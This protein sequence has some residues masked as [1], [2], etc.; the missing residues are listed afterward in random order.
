MPNVKS[1]THVAERTSRL[2]FSDIVRIRNRVLDMIGR[3]I[4]VLRLEGGEPF[5][6]TP[7]F[8][9]QALK[10][11]VDA[12]QTR[13]A[14]SSG[15]PDLL[16]AI[17]A[18][19][20]SKNR[21]TVPQSSVIVTSGGAHGL[22][23]A[24]QATVN[25]GDEVML[26][27]PFW[28]PIR[29]HITYAGG[30]PVTVPW[31]EVRGRDAA[32][33]ALSSRL[34]PLTRVIYLNTPGN[35]T[36]DVL[37]R[38]QLASIAEFAIANDLT[39][40]ADEAYE[41]LQYEG[42]HVSIASMPGMFE[43]TLTVFTLSKSFAMTGWRAGY[44]VADEAFMEVLRKL[45]LNSINGVS[46][47]TQFAA[48]A[49]I[50]QGQPFVREMLGQYRKRRDRLVA[51]LNGAGFR[52][53]TP[54]GAF[55]VF[56]DVSERLG[57]DSWKAMESLLEKTSIASVPGVVFGAEGEGHLRMSCSLSDSLLEQAV[58]ALAKL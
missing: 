7:D 26:F 43:R 5:A 13:Y 31:E 18:K 22:F 57:P 11:A 20:S 56:P 16:S 19:L 34:T 33:V 41:D 1:H 30:I 27:S 29:D 44:L 9:K 37:T 10:D 53:H 36:G 14:P 40:I 52:C 42:E 45:V 32:A 4:P 3:G 50:T 28:T 17:T 51:A 25:P 39:V 35:P 23:C 38:E 24:F 55:Y 49:A 6:P 46:T 58:A 15:V 21:M 8:I 48:A 54:P 47:P 2:G 12:N